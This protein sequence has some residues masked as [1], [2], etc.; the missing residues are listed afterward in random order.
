[1]ADDF[2]PDQIHRIFLEWQFCF[3]NKREL[4]AKWG[5]TPYRLGVWRKQRD[6]SRRWT[7]LDAVIAGMFRGGWV[8]PA[9]L[10]GWLDYVDHARY[11]E[12]QVRGMLER[13]E[14][15]GEVRR[16]GDRWTWV[17]VDPPYVFGP[18]DQEA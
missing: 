5:I 15:R 11:S 13:L 2:T 9:E 3:R 18:R 6:P 7:I 17:Q 16:E 10:I 1:V 8:T 14:A 4:C 12:Q